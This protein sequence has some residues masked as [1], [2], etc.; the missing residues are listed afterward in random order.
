MTTSKTE[1]DEEWRS[2]P[3][4]NH[5]EVSD[6]GRVRS[7]DHYARC[8]SGATRL[9]RGRVLK[10]YRARCGSTV[11]LSE[12][13]V[14]RGTT[15]SRLVVAAFMGRDLEDRSWV[16]LHE[17]GEA[18]DN[19]LSNLRASTQ[20]DVVAHMGLRDATLKG[21]AHPRAKLDRFR[22]REI[23]DLLAMGRGCTGISR[24]YGVSRRTIRDIAAG[25]AWRDVEY[26]HRFSRDDIT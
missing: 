25:R 3:G 17:N 18:H 6:L 21:E 11:D 9:C 4:W 1:H 7:I 12:Y 2:V 15:V 26:G 22:V 14:R 23:I 19:H 24:E 20:K 5:Y 13:D 10:I 16:A 8:K